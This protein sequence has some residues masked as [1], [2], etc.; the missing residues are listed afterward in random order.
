MGN[1]AISGNSPKARSSV[2]ESVNARKSGKYAKLREDVEKSFS[3]STGNVGKHESRG[4]REDKGK[5]PSPPT[6]SLDFYDYATS[7]EESGEVKKKPP[8]AQSSPPDIRHD[9]STET[10][11]EVSRGKRGL[12][13]CFQHT[14]HLP[15][16]NS[17]FKELK[18]LLKKELSENTRTQYDISFECSKQNT[19]LIE[20]TTR[21]K[22]TLAHGQRPVALDRA[23]KSALAT[24]SPGSNFVTYPSNLK[25]YTLDNV[26]YRSKL[27]GEV[28]SIAEEI[29]GAVFKK[30]KITQH[31][32]K[33]CVAYK[34]SKSGIKSDFKDGVSDSLQPEIFIFLNA[35]INVLLKKGMSQDEIASNSV[36]LAG[37]VREALSEK[38]GLNL[39]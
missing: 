2:D 29:L 7:S 17:R 16:D 34:V 13:L 12:S 3:D 25:K 37:P 24:M 1:K 15:F 30:C 39:V 33:E 32:D 8:M 28:A 14:T 27:A 38:Y 9:R 4:L 5:K 11:P 18:T 23:V 31:N 19:I 6:V 22:L 35:R 10:K 20:F 26:P 36:I 21:E